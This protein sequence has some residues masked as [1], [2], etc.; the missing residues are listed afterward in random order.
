MSEIGRPPREETEPT[1][2]SNP[3][4]MSS[5]VMFA[6]DAEE[7]PQRRAR[8]ARVVSP[9]CSTKRRAAARFC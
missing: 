5:E 3:S 6:A 1:S 9:C 7:N 2:A 4:S 8:S